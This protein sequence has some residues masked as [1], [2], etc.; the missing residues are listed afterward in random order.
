MHDLLSLGRHAF[1]SLWTP[2]HNPAWATQRN[3]TQD[4]CKQLEV[5]TALE[6]LFCA[7]RDLKMDFL[8]LYFGL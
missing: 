7:N 4:R 6:M 3:A 2:L 5:A 1:T 8:E